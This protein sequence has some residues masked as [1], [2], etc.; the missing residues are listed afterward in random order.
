M[1]ALGQ[2]RIVFCGGGAITDVDLL[3]SAATQRA[4]AV[5]G[6]AQLC[7]GR[8]PRDHLVGA[9]GTILTARCYVGFGVAGAPHHLA[10]LDGV[11]EVISVN[12]DP[13]APLHDRADLALIADAEAVLRCLAAARSTSPPQAPLP[14]PAVRPPVDLLERMLLPPRG[15]GLRIDH[16]SPALAAQLIDAAL[17]ATHPGEPRT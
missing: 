14:R 1:S 12:L 16:A 5:G 2:A 6:T 4:A 10:A 7:D 11:A 3:R 17:A 15:R 13:W 8:L 9:S